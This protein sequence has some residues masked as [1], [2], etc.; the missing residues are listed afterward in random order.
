M[1][2]GTLRKINKEEIGEE[3]EQHSSGTIE[4]KKTTEMQPNQQGKKEEVQAYNPPVPFPP[5]L[6]FFVLTFLLVEQC[7]KSATTV[8]EVCHNHARGM[9]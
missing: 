9:P 2:R 5:V 7:S 6:F 4:T 1:K 3:L 8:L